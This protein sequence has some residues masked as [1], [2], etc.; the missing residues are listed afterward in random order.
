MLCTSREFE[1]SSKGNTDIH[2]VTA[3]V[4]RIVTEEGLRE[5][6][7]TVFTPGATASVSTIEFE[8]G[9]VADLKEAVRRT[10][11]EDLHYRHDARWGDGN[12]FSHVRAALGGPS[13][14]VPVTSGSLTLG[15]WQQIIVLDHDNRPR[16]RRVVV[17]MMG[18]E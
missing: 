3:Q 17:Q 10:A 14:T 16:K 5:G 4:Q 11:P 1:L 6:I 7:V 15:T 2:D 12:G 8:S 13:L 18:T 9:A